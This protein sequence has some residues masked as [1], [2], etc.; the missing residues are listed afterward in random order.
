MTTVAQPIRFLSL[1][2]GVGGLDVGLERAGWR[3]VGMC[4]NDPKASRVLRTRWPHVPL[5]DDV[6]TLDGTAVDCDAVVGGFPCVDISSNGAKVGIH[7]EQSGLFFEAMRIVRQARPRWVLLENVADLVAR[8]LGTVLAE[9]AALR[10][11]AW[12]DVLPAA[13]FGAPQRRQ[14][15]FVAAHAGGRRLESG[16]Q[17]HAARSE[18]ERWMHHDGLGAGERRAEDGPRR[19]RGMDERVSGRVDRLRMLGNCVVPQVG[20]ALGHAINAADA[21][22]NASLSS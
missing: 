1:F 20:M 12:W 4:E 7:G 9:L 6:R 18:L 8:G 19:L 11:H 15:T 3:C 14:R 21:V 22:L 5:Y 10:F 13:A 17:W 16:H 2:S